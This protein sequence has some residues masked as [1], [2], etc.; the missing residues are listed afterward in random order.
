MNLKVGYEV[1]GEAPVFLGGSGTFVEYVLAAVVPQF[2]RSGSLSGRGA[3]SA[4]HA[5]ST[6]LSVKVAHGHAMSLYG[7]GKRAMTGALQ[8]AH[9]VPL[10]GR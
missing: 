1:F 6:A 10:G 4:N 2:G 5:W 8:P 9:F 3:E 7:G